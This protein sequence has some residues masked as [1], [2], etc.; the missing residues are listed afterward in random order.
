M[1]IDPV[2]WV[3]H[4]GGL[5]GLTALWVQFPLAIEMEPLP[6]RAGGTVRGGL[7]LR[8]LLGAANGTLHK[9][10]LRVKTELG[11][12]RSR[13]SRYQYEG[14]RFKVAVPQGHRGR[15]AL[16]SARGQ[17]GKEV[18]QG[19]LCLE[20]QMEHWHHLWRPPVELNLTNGGRLVG[21]LSL[22]VLIWT[23]SVLEEGEVEGVPPNGDD[24]I[25]L[26]DVHV[27]Q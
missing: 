17:G 24:G 19:I 12:H 9:L 7:N 4:V 6:V 16:I 8:S 11:F 1:D 15:H 14:G 23:E 13:T 20:S 18:G 27:A 10:S 21:R 2:E 3:P 26:E 5:G 22:R 25:G